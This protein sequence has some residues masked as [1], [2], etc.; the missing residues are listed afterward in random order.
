MAISHP[1]VIKLFPCSTQPST[2]LI[3][4]INVIIP[5]I[6]GIL[7]LISMINTTS[8]RLEARNFFICRYFRFYEQLKFRAQ[9]SWAWKKGSW[10]NLGPDIR[11]RYCRFGSF[12]ECFIFVDLMPKRCQIPD[13]KLKCNRPPDKSVYWK[14][15][16]FISHPKHMLWVL[17]RTVSMRQFVWA[18]KTHVQING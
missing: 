16:F 6:A 5:T 2:K 14:I 8:E 13:H 11:T 3:L 15:I 9:L 7:T 4:L 17:K 10:K 18:P 12:R 1:E